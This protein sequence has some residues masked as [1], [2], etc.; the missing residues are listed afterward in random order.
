MENEVK[1]VQEVQNGVQTT[2]RDKTPNLEKFDFAGLTE[3]TGLT[4]DDLV[5][6][7]QLDELLKYWGVKTDVLPITTIIKKD[8]QEDKTIKTSGRLSIRTSDDGTIK[9]NIHQYRKEP[10]FNREFIGHTFTPE[11][12]Q[13][14]KDTCTLGKVVELKP[15]DG[16]PFKAYVG[17]DHTINEICY[18]SAERL[19]LPDEILGHKFSN[20]EK[21][22]LTNGETI[23]VE[24][25]VSKNSQ[26]KY[27]VHFQVNPSRNGLDMVFPSSLSLENRQKNMNKREEILG[28]KLSDEQKKALN[29]GEFVLIKGMTSKRD[30]KMKFDAEVRVNLVKGDIMFHYPKNEQKKSQD[31]KQ[32]EA[33]TS[34]QNTGEDKKQ[35]QK[36]ANK[37]KI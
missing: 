35:K 14:L 21:E 25:M 28:V 5:K 30:P 4:K 6:M 15:K 27:D 33:Q 22:K 23:K 36:K 37:A 16:E 19:K 26:K 3:S 1:D 29:R 32:D 18:M 24:G 11:D 13:M 34:K 9:F 10:D 2:E 8:G 12:I 17:I 31:N 20:E 7:G